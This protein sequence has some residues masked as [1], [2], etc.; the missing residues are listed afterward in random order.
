MYDIVADI[1][2]YPRFLNWCRDAKIVE[3]VDNGVVAKIDIDYKG[4]KQSFTTKNVNENA[5]SIIMSLH[6]DQGSFE[7]LGGG[8]NFLSIDME[9]QQA[10]KV[11][12]NLDFSMNNKITA[13][14]FKTF[15]QKIVHSQVDGFIKRAEE[16]YK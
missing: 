13:T 3:Q 4:I 1:E 16:L 6:G 9:G 14:I 2:V 11:E 8:W 10:C 15:F 12:F 5:K 7:H